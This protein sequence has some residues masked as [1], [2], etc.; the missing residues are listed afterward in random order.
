VG[1]QIG[2]ASFRTLRWTAGLR[3]LVPRS[4]LLKAYPV[5][6][7]GNFRVSSRSLEFFE[8]WRLALEFTSKS[9]RTPRISKATTKEVP[10]V[11]NRIP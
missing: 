5:S 4:R 10:P 3:E 11:T 8:S 2:A 9:P 6:L 1:D 7:E